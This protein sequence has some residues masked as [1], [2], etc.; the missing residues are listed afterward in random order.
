MFSWS[1]KIL[2]QAGQ[3]EISGEN[4]TSESFWTG[5]LPQADVKEEERSSISQT[6]SNQSE[7]N[8]YLDY[9]RLIRKLEREERRTARDLNAL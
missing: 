4:F 5:E 7:G 2:I 9:D 8:E 6:E 1:R 3:K